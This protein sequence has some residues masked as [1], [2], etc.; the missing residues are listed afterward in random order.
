MKKIAHGCNLSF[1]QPL[2]PHKPELDLL[3]KELTP[4]EVSQ[5]DLKVTEH[6]LMSDDDSILGHL[7]TL[8]VVILFSEFLIMKQ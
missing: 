4:D 2:H 8:S 7:Q 1:L 6:S 5:I 3:R